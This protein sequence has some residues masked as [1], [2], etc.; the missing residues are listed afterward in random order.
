MFYIHAGGKTLGPSRTML[1]D[2]PD[3][4][5]SKYEPQLINNRK[6][7]R[8]KKRRS[9][10]YLVGLFVLTA[11]HDLLS[12]FVRLGLSAKSW[13]VISP[14]Q[15][16]VNQVM[17]SVWAWR[18][19]LDQING[20]CSFGFQAKWEISFFQ[21]IKSVPMADLL[22]FVIQS[23]EVPS[24]SFVDEHQSSRCLDQVSRKV[25]WTMLIK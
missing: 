20:I 19:F 9:A 10:G 2:S 16:S 17:K 5:K 4:G 22:I 23:M 12:G 18:A 24:L 1:V 13:A 8:C 3:L 21:V 6:L 15:Y 25:C 14:W 7:Y 11:D